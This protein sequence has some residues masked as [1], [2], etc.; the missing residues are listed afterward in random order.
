MGN[1]LALLCERI[2]AP[3]D[4]NYLIGLSGG[5][6][7]VALTMMLLPKIRD[8]RVHAAAVHVNHGL[9]SDESDEDERFVRQLCAALKI[10]CLVYRPDLSGRSDEAAARRARFEC[11]RQAIQETGADGLLLAHHAD[12]QAE[13]FLMRLLRGAGADGLQCMAREQV[14]EGIR[15]FRPML[16]LGR[17][18]IREALIQDGITWREDSSNRDRAYLRNRIRM[19]AIP[20][21]EEI[22]PGAVGRICGAAGMIRSD[23]ETLQNA[24]RERFAAAAAA[25]QLSTDELETAPEAIQSRVLR[26]W[27]RANAP[28]LE[29]HELS[30]RQTRQLLGL[31]KSEKGKVNLPGGYHAVRNPGILFLT[32]PERETP[33]P[34]EVE[35]PETGFSGFRLT[36]TPSQGNP[37]DGRRTQE[38]PAGF[39]IGCQIRTRRPGDRIRPFGSSGSRK[40]QDYLTDRK[41]PEPYR[42]RIPLLCRGEEVLL[43][44]GVG[45][46]NIPRWN[47]EGQNV[48]LTW[49][50][51]MPWLRT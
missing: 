50:G 17:E 12:D 45:A 7:S 30:S 2:C 25:D 27:W 23:N 38:V 14:V 26:M 42:D 34:V 32:G 5:A 48:R 4:G 28:K 16:D 49:T 33:S 10:E 6:D 15:V 40:L 22:A 13:T 24:A 1:A 36:E 51:E 37:G 11:F 8:G 43:V 35:G 21:L 19:E 9:R 3:E 29:E 44:C 47:A 41:I 18:E 31:L 39:T 46:G 20:L